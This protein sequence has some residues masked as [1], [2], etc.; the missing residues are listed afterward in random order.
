M[1]VEYQPDIPIL[2]IMGGD[3]THYGTTNWGT[4]E[5]RLKMASL[6]F[7]LPKP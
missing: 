6:N 5:N 1:L 4:G 2:M 3:L 7:R